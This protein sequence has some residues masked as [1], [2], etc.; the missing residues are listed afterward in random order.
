M[1][2]YKNEKAG[3]WFCKFYFTDWTGTRKQKKKEG[4]QTKR[5]AQEFEREFLNKAHA[6][7]D[8]TFGSLVQL[9]M[10]DSK[11]RLKPT[12]YSNKEFII[13]TK[14]LPFF[15]DM[16]INTITPATIRKWQNEL[17]SD[18]RKYSQ[19]YLKTVNNQASAV[20]NYAVKYYRLENNPCRLAGT[21]GKKNADEME[22]WTVDEFNRFIKAVEDKP[23][24]KV[25]FN[26]LFWTGMRSGEMLALT[27][28]D[29][30]FQANTVSI[31]KNYARHNR[32]DLILPPKTPK[33]K[34]VITLPP[35][36]SQMVR[37]YS[38]SIYANDPSGRLF[39]QTKHYLL[40][41]MIRGCKKSG[42]KRI[43]IH[44]LR[45]SHA[46]FLIE[47]GFSPLLIADRL[48]HENIE[49]TLQ[50]YSHLYPN[51]HSEVATLIEAE[52]NKT[53]P[54]ERKRSQRS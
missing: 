42:V 20:F 40:H 12:T 3:S 54:A 50:T 30:D 17:L 11:T 51:K 19:T 16:P 22:I 26:L 9:Y 47:K 33:S 46:S 18:P 35:F 1:P 32:E 41:E 52:H 23:T 6:S 4:F 44:D 53:I 25:I 48:G 28:E 8:M 37:A 36:L 27:V 31:S 24:S 38:T 39:G 15:K 21:M 49:T 5:E 45:H 13:N 10:E 7:C 43:R 14:L 29:F 2:V 34:R